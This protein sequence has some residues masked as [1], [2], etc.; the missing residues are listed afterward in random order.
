[1]A[2]NDQLRERVPDLSCTGHRPVF[3]LRMMAKVQQF[4]R[5]LLLAA[6]VLG[7]NA[8]SL[9]ALTHARHPGHMR[10]NVSH[11][12]HSASRRASRDGEGPDADA[13]AVQTDS[14]HADS[15][16]PPQSRSAGALSHLSWFMASPTRLC[17]PDVASVLTAAAPGLAWPSAPR[18][19][20]GAR[21]PPLS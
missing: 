7:L 15:C 4:G 16:V 6:L 20:G 17:V 12:H 11:G 3:G 13:D 14:N 2:S 18:A 21:A 9:L 10:A 5:T 19:P 8:L 1:M